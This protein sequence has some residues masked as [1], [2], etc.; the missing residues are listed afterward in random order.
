V[1]EEAIRCL[2]NAPDLLLFDGQGIAHPRGMGIAAHMG[3]VLGI[4]SV[5]C[6][7]SRL[8]GEYREPGRKKGSRST[9]WMRVSQASPH[10]GTE[11]KS[12]V[13]AVLRSRDGVKPVFVSPGHLIDIEGSVLMVLAFAG[14]YRLPEPLRRAHIIAQ[15]AKKL[16]YT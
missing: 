13:G 8:V 15:K 12:P 9:L 11:R 1:L 2:T 4:P 5:G 7:K 6:A 3:V 14:R 16:C 10:A